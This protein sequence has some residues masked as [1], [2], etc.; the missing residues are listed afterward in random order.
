MTSPRTTPNPAGGGRVL[1]FP[2]FRAVIAPDG[3][4]ATLNGQQVPTAG[5]PDLLTAV[6]AAAATAAT[7]LGNRPIRMDVTTPTGQVRHLTAHPTTTQP[8]T[9]HP[10]T[11]GA[12]VTDPPVPDPTGLPLCPAPRAPVLDRIPTGDTDQ[13]PGR[14]PQRPGGPVT[15]PPDHSPTA[16]TERRHPAPAAHPTRRPA[17]PRPPSREARGHPDLPAAAP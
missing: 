1:P 12:A 9:A 5:F 4:S 13:D 17:P 8:S 10:S 3:A 11:A 6:H 14:G 7:H 15:T 16:A 2:I